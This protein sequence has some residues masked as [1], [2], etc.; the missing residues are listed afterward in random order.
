M[1]SLCGWNAFNYRVGGSALLVWVLLLAIGSAL[2]ALLFFTTTPENLP[3]YH[4]VFSFAAFLAAVAWLNIITGE[5]VSLFESW[6][7]IF[8]V[9]HNHLYC[10]TCACNI[11][12]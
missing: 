12:A 5:V 9:K 3:P 1:F 6:G 8:N 4:L 7:L 2:S 11:Y 10:I